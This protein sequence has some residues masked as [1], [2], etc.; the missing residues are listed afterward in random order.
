VYWGKADE[1]NFLA[2]FMERT[3][4]CIC[5]GRDAALAADK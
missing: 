5:R 1:R 2:W 4:A 3:P